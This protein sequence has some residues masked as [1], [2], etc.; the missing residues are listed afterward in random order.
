MKR[1]TTSKRSH[2]LP[3]A[4]PA[5]A[6]GRAGPSVLAALRTKIDAIDQRLIHLLHDRSALVVAVGKA[7]QYTGTPIYAPHRE[8]EVLERVL[9]L[10]TESGGLLAER[11]I[12][13]I[14][15]EIMSGSIQLER[16][17]RIGY[18]G[19]KGSFSH[20]ASIKHFGSSA[21]FED[22]HA[23]EGVFS[24]VARGHCDY[25]L[26][27][28]ENS[29]IGGIAE[30]LDQLILLSEPARGKGHAGKGLAVRICAE[31]QLEIS[32]AFAAACAPSEVKRIYSKPEVFA[33][34][35]VWLATQY[36]KAELIPTASSSR[37][38]QMVAEMAAAAK[39]SGAVCD[40]AAVGSVLAAELY[41]LSVLFDRIADSAE[42]I[43]RFFVLGRHA[44][45]R[46]GR[47]KTAIMF[48][49]LNKPGALVR[50]LGDFEAQGVNLTHIEKRP[51]G[52]K[53]FSYTFFV[54]AEGHATDEPVANAIAAAAEHCKE[55]VVLGS[56]PASRRVL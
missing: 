13:G 30:T 14:W 17:M 49:T 53:N 35:R 7:K 54:D 9:R 33:Q 25:G 47:D 45:A 46:C 20:M 19:P 3:P 43:T 41:G 15:R 44:V 42:N 50:V 2:S 37:A 40:G 12:E 6:K 38:M 5:A 56:F 1:R 51:S 34:C 31:V 29:M 39:A 11:A 16:P 52:R 8:A 18:L 26:V 4:K 48:S 32:H 22:L 55:L 28:I 36:P 21:S 24:E 27:P 23:I 10:N